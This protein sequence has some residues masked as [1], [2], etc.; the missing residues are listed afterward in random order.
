[1]LVSESLEMMSRDP[2]RDPWE[3]IDHICNPA[4][5]F[6][7]SQVP[8]GGCVTKWIAS[9]SVG[10]PTGNKPQR[11]TRHERESICMTRFRRSSVHRGK[12]KLQDDA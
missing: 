2:R 9:C 11:L 5:H 6:P 4:W 7:S 1:M 12:C 3:G 10:F 8:W